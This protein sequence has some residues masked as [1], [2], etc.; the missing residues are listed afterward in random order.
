MNTVNVTISID[1]NRLWQM[2]CGSAWESWSWWLG[3]RYEGGDWDMPCNLWV[4]AD[5]PDDDG[6]AVTAV[7]TVE[8]LANALTEMQDHAAV[9]E[10]L[11]NDDFD[12]VYGDAVMQQAVF[13]QVIYG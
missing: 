7:I 11:V 6:A 9:M 13:G 8:D 12:A 5:D 3:W 1:R 2:V 4:I 10:C